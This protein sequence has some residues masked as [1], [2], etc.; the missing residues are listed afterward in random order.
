M[1]RCKKCG[2]YH[3]RISKK[4]NTTKIDSKVNLVEYK[5][6]AQ[7]ITTKA[8]SNI[9]DSVWAT[10]A[11]TLW[12]Q[13]F[14]GNGVLIGVID[15]GID[16]THPALVGKVVKR[17]DY[18]KDGKA[19]ILYNPH[20]T[21]V[22]GTIAANSSILKGVAPKANLADYRVLD[23]NGSGSFVNVTRAIIDATN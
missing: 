13:G 6:T 9:P 22:A 5:I 8:T 12:N 19:S 20:G 4:K 17:R 11:T 3:K 21:H 7:Q 15:T 16:D 10:G 1:G 2:K 18:V 14:E 23:V